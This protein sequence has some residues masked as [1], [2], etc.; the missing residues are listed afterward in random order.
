MQF[1]WGYLCGSPA[2]APAVGVGH[3]G[4][5]LLITRPILARGVVKSRVSYLFHDPA[6]ELLDRIA[7]LFV[8]PRKPGPDATFTPSHQSHGGYIQH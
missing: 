2:F 6:F 1:P 7:N 3:L 8:N 5:T 4:G